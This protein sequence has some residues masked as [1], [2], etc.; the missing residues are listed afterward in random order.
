MEAHRVLRALSIALFAILLA[1]PRAQAGMLAG[2]CR[3]SDQPAATLLLP[4]FEVD[5]DAPNGATTI[6]SINN[7]SPKSELARVVLWTD[8]GIPTLAFDVYLT[9]YDVQT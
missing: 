9:G 6:V 2:N 8:W 4:Y 3:V 7:A 5:L 1:T